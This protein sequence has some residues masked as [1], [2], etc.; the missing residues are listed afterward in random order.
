MIGAIFAVGAEQD[1]HHG[2]E[3]FHAAR[4]GSDL[5]DH[6]DPASGGRHVACAG[7][8]A[9]RWLDCRDAAIVRGQTDAARSVTAE[10]ERRSARR[11]ECRF[12]AAGAAGCSL[13]VVGIVGAAEK[14]VIAFEGEEQVWEIGAGD[15]DGSGSAQ[16]RDE[17]GIVSR[18]RV[19]AITERA[20]R[21][22]RACDFDG[23]FD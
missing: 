13:Q 7:Q 20:G 10:S 22:D 18:W 4:H 5:P 21:A 15:G 14:Q 23:V 8:P 3:I 17:S 19:V 12:S 2:P 16:T 6:F 9:G 1:R 11:D